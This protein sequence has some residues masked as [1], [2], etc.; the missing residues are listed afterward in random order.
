MT[1]RT[2]DLAW[3]IAPLDEGRFRAEHWEQRP[4]LL[5]REDRGYYDGLLSFDD[6]DRL[7]GAGWLANSRIRLIRDG[8][9]LKAETFHHDLGKGERVA[10]PD[11]VASHYLS[12]GTVAINQLHDSWPPLAELCASLESVFSQR[13]Q[14]NV[15]FTP[16]QGQGFAA[17]YDTHDVFVLQVA[18]RKT[19]RVYDD[20]PIELPLAEQSWKRSQGPEPPHEK[21]LFETEMRTGDL[22]YLPRGYVHEARTSEDLSLHLTVGIISLT[23][24][25]LAK[26]AIDLLARKDV[27]FR[28]TPPIGY[29]AGGE[30]LEAAAATLAGLVPAIGARETVRSV[31]AGLEE[32]SA[33][34]VRLVLGPRLRE[35]ERAERLTANDVVERRL[36]V[37]LATQLED[38]VLRLRFGGKTVDLPDL[39]EDLVAFVRVTPRFRISELPPFLGP[40]GNLSVIRA[41]VREGLLVTSPEP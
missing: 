38:D 28:R 6:V 41:L 19:W 18:G 11:K 36:G 5:R 22:L 9:E 15:Y 12:G 26:K 27:R 23:Y 20:P 29:L 32:S 13:V 17:H 1:R 7:L 34:R 8:D 33:N 4:L 2:F 39:A 14:T 3:M 10:N 24:A 35:A 21:L 37:S 25:D 40:S 30:A 16:S 31:A